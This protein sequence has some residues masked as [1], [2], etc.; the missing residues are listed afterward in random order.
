[1]LKRTLLLAAVAAVP[2]LLASGAAAP[3]AAQ[4][5]PPAGIDKI[6]T[7]VLIY[8]ENRSFDNLYGAFPG[9]NG[10]RNAKHPTQF[11]R[12][13]TRLKELPPVWDGLTAKGVTPVV[14]QAQT[15]HLPNRPFA[16]DDPKG[17]NV[18]L[19][20]TTHDLWHRFYQ[21]QMQIDGGRND[22]FVAW[23]DS[24]GLVMGHYDGGPSCRCGRSRSNTCW[25]TISS[26]ARS[27]ARSSTISVPGLRLRAGLSGCGQEPGEAVDRCGR[28]GTA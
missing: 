24:G 2:C 13:G 11:D 20:V 26:W 9:A 19:D 12:D 21:N 8:A 18:G 23:A 6:Q 7:I 5:K 22:R 10:L 3:A 28:T 1:M 14:T 17:F 4:R 25:P 15:E 27:A 16:I